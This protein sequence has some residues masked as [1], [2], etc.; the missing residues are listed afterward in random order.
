M[1]ASPDAAPVPA[2]PQTQALLQ[3]L[4]RHHSRLP[5]G[6]YLLSFCPPVPSPFS[7][8]RAFVQ[9]PGVLYACGFVSAVIAGMGILSLDILYGTVWTAG[10][11]GPGVTPEQIRSV[12]TRTAWIMAIVSGIYFIFCWLFLACF[13]AASAA[14]TQ[15]LRHAYIA[16]VLS[17]DA[18]YHD[19]HGAGEVATHAGKECGTIR[20]ALGEKLGFVVWSLSTLVSSVTVGFIKNSRVAGTLFALIPF[21]VILFSLLAMLTERIGGPMLRL[22]GRASSFLEECLGGVRVTQAFGMREHLVERFDHAMLKPLARLGMKRAAIRGGENGTFYT[23]LMLSYA[24]AFFAIARFRGETGPSLTAFWNFLNSLFCLANI[25]PMLSAL[26]DATTATNHLRRTIERVPLID[27]RDPGGLRLP[28]E[29][30]PSI[31]LKNVVMAY[32]SRPNVPSLDGVSVTFPAGKVTALVGQS[33]SGKSTITELL[34]RAYDP[35]TANLRQASDEADDAADR[36]AMGEKLE[37]KEGEQKPKKKLF[38]GRT[39]SIS[40]AEDPEKA[41]EK[42]KPI[43]EVPQVQGA[44]EVYLDGHDLRDLNLSW[45]RSQIAIVRQMPQITT[46]SI[47]ENVAAGLTGTELEYRPQDGGVEAMDASEKLRY[48]QIRERVSAALV[49]AQAFDFVSRLPSG[50][51]TQVSG[52]KTGLLSGGQRQRIAIARALI[53]EPKLLILDEG[54]SAL[55]SQ[56]E[57]LIRDM[58]QEEQRRRGMT[59]ILIAHRLSTIA[60][61]DQIVVMRNGRII[62]RAS[63]TNEASAHTQLMDPKR[64]NDA[65]LYRTMVLTQR[66][67]ATAEN[68]NSIKTGLAEETDEDETS[69]LELLDSDGVT[70][71]V[72]AQS[73]R[74][75]S[76]P[77]S[78]LQQR[79][80]PLKHRTSRASDHPPVQLAGRG[81]TTMAHVEQAAAEEGLKGV[82]TEEEH[83]ELKRQSKRERRRLLVHFGRLLRR[84]WFLFLVGLIGAILVGAA[85]PIAGW[86]TGGGVNALTIDRITD[87]DRRVRESN[88]YALY[89]FLL[90]VA[91]LVLVTLHSCALEFASERLLRRLKRQSFAAVL[92]QEIGFFDA[93]ENH[94]GSLTASVS[95]SPASVAAATGLT[96]SQLIVSCTNLVGS[97]ILAFILSWKAAVVVLAPLV[98][99]FVSSWLNVVM[100]ERYE[101]KVSVPAGKAA[102]YVAENVDAMKEIAALGR[103]LEV[104]RRFDE[105]ARTEPKRTQYLI[106]GAGGFAISQVSR[107]SSARINDP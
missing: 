13:T 30:P 25:V 53:R 21:C 87:N 97:V 15:R 58:L 92:L 76:Q 42:T 107:D 9:H 32:P 104:M 93:P 73:T 105:Q 83:A 85:F 78:S 24:T 19:R 61:A 3:T 95:S 60:H 49:K 41:D 28:L 86:L 29:Q 36:A 48:E 103:E 4:H 94:A 101:S 51:D 57:A 75:P 33:G 68:D 81:A 44:G 39:K 88:R 35:L 11:T 79:P 74:A 37:P 55:D 26:I 18:A 91:S 106:W 72:A 98:I 69:S 31:E 46:A 82:S 5:G 100:L 102:S 40:S 89:F 2:P 6:L 84:Y 23:T 22:E 10:I 16:S 90:A 38:G 47:F 1:V 12:S 67:I 27:V 50:M 62:D 20:V 66:H 56:S 34:M 65:N 7:S 96:S 54:T 45:L 8:P 99:L 14:L 63:T 52:G 17:Q 70:T 80:V 59:T 71:R 77:S 43:N 64:D